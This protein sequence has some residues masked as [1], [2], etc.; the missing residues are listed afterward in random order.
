VKLEAS[1]G[2][3]NSRAMHAM[4]LDFAR[5]QDTWSHAEHASRW[6]WALP[7][8]E[9]A[10]RPRHRDALA[11]VVAYA[12]DVMATARGAKPPPSGGLSDHSREWTAQAASDLETFCDKL[13][14]E[15]RELGGN[16]VGLT[17]DHAH[18]DELAQRGI[19]AQAHTMLLAPRHHLR[20]SGRLPRVTLSER[21]AVPT[22]L[23]AAFMDEHATASDSSLEVRRAGIRVATKIA[24][25]IRL[26][27]GVD[28]V[29]LRSDEIHPRVL[30]DARCV[31]AMR[32]EVSPGT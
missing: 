20:D 29:V 9:I 16:V 27:L 28:L 10:A 1:G 18:A 11:F 15:F 26:E 7:R 23:F 4:F 19:F 3:K 12:V 13:S 21:E 6:S 31:S 22:N 25:E 8:W 2:S 32:D 30:A 14:D 17:R 5:W 24:R